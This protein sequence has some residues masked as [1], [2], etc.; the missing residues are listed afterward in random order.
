MGKRSPSSSYSSR[1]RARIANACASASAPDCCR[2]SSTLTVTMTP[3]IG[4][5]G[6]DC[7]RRARKPFQA[8]ASTS[9]LLSWVVYRPAVSRNT[10][11]SVNHQ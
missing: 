7:L 10:A 11:S 2:M 6:R 4:R 3:L 1:T 5:R 9:W 8:A